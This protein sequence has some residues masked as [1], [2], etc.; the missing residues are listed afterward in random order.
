VGTPLPG[1]TP[2]LARGGSRRSGFAAS[3]CCPALLRC[4]LCPSGAPRCLMRLRTSRHHCQPVAT[5]RRRLATSPSRAA[6]SPSCKLSAYPVAALPVRVCPG[7]MARSS[8][9]ASAGDAA[10]RS[11][12]ARHPPP[13]R[14]LEL[15]GSSGWVA[16]RN[17]AGWCQVERGGGTQ[18]NGRVALG[19]NL[20]AL[21]LPRTHSHSHSYEWTASASSSA[22]GLAKF[23]VSTIFGS[24][25]SSLSHPVVGSITKP[26]RCSYTPPYRTAAGHRNLIKASSVGYLSTHLG[27]AA[28]RA[29]G[30]GPERRR[31]PTCFHPRTRRGA[32]PPGASA[33]HAPRRS[34]S[35]RSRCGGVARGLVSV[36]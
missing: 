1:Q 17:G 28:R 3:A 11:S 14:P 16:G 5:R 30:P 31:R 7:R 10:V 24:S 6:R 23:Q 27:V 34:A 18:R 26:L 4:S 22:R 21:G 8:P 36:A 2:R 33:A 9:L 35:V 15:N 13:P 20:R 29:P 12:A 19:S 25:S 32:W